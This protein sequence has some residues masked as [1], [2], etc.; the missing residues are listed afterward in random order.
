MEKG[1]S[2]AKNAISNLV[3]LQD[4]FRVMHSVYS[5]ALAF[6][7]RWVFIFNKV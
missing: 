3:A 4:Q 2:L 7:W 6:E 1:L 5:D